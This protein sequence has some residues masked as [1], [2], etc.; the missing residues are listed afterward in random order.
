MP[1]L[2]IDGYTDP[3]MGQHYSVQGPY[4]GTHDAAWWTLK[5]D[6]MQSFLE[7]GTLLPLAMQLP[8]YVTQYY[9]NDDDEEATCT[10]QHG[11]H[12]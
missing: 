11:V 5:T 2:S 8:T 7:V 3:T 1:W 4:L 10:A 9:Y 6:P 12:A